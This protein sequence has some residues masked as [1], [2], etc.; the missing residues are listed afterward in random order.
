MS[1]RTTL[2]VYVDDIDDSQGEAAVLLKQQFIDYVKNN[3]GRYVAEDYK[4]FPGRERIKKE[5]GRLKNFCVKYAS[6]ELI[7][8]DR[9]YDAAVRGAAVFYRSN[10]NKTRQ[11]TSANSA[12][13][14]HLYLLSCRGR[15][16]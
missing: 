7:Y 4:D 2:Q 3:G 6:D 10:T 16:C 5:E 1:K 15:S 12:S 13:L 14:C 11:C 8:R 9:T